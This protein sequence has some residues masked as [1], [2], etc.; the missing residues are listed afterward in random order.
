MRLYRVIE[1][2]DQ[3]LARQDL[4]HAEDQYLVQVMR[5]KLAIDDFDIAHVSTQSSPVCS[6][7]VTQTENV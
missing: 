1:G 7:I 2:K 6:N 4:R 5:N 3:L